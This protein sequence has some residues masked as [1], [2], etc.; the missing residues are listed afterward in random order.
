MQPKILENIYRE[1]S[2]LDSK[3]RLFF[4]SWSLKSTCLHR[5]YVHTER[6]AFD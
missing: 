4:R 5:K 2:K 3:K 6:A 1:I